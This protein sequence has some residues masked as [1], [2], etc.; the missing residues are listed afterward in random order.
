M[1]V[2]QI[3]A[4]VA[5]PVSLDEAKAHLRVLDSSEDALI[6]ALLSSAVSMLDGRDGALGRALEPQVWELSIDGFPEVIVLPLGPVTAVASIT[7]I[8]VAGAAVVLPGSQYQV[9]LTG[10]DGR[11]VAS[12]GWPETA[13]VPSAVKVRWSAGGSVP[14][15]IRTAILL[16]V[17]HWYLEREGG[18]GAA[19]LPPAVAAIVRQFRR[20]PL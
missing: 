12:G 16:L 17:G 13:D 10:V 11:I 7:Y 6:G 4:P 20:Y 1:A 8:D 15:A 2:Y 3:T 14:A 9:D 19:G 18:E 5:L